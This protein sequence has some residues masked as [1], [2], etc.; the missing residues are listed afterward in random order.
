LKFGIDEKSSHSDK[1]I[2]DKFESPDIEYSPDPIEEK[3][4]NKSKSSK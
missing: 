1:K 4:L 3:S 2:S